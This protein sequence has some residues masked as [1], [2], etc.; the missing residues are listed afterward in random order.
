MK[1]VTAILLFV[2]CLAILIGFN[3]TSTR[4]WYTL[5]GVIIVVNIMAGYLLLKK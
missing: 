4:Y 5:D 3:F 1:K 2:I